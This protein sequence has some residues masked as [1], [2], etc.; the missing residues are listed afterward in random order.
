MYL[1]I[2]AVLYRTGLEF[3]TGSLTV[4]LP[5]MGKLNGRRVLVGITGGIAAYKSVELTRRLREH[6]AEVRVV[7][8]PA[9][10]KFITPLTLQA[11]SGNP[12]HESLLD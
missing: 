4:R 1:P 9:A 8:T 3:P 2:C 6:G 10:K 11:T 5:D 12:V 7:L